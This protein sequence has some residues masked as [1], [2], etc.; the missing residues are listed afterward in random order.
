MLQCCDDCGRPVEEYA[1]FEVNQLMMCEDCF[2]ESK[3]SRGWDGNESCASCGCPPSLNR[4]AQCPL[5][6]LPNPLG[7]VSPVVRQRDSTSSHDDSKSDAAREEEPA[8]SKTQEHTSDLYSKQSLEEVN[9]DLGRQVSEDTRS[10][11][12]ISSSQESSAERT[13][14]SGTEKRFPR[15]TAKTSADPIRK[16]ETTTKSQ[17]NEANTRPD[18]NR[19]EN[20]SQIPDPEERTDFGKLEERGRVEKSGC[21]T[22]TTFMLLVPLLIV[23]LLTLHAGV[24]DWGALETIQSTLTAALVAPLER[25]F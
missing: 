12:N 1:T 21:L 4:T 2:V 6:G 24:Q 11:N 13:N 7:G 18:K 20:S 23:V 25:Q 3:S 15:P 22:S 5:C 9:R 19:Q 10:H 17:A 16:P 14:Q 8:A